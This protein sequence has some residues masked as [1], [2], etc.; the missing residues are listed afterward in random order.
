MGQQEVYE[1]LKKSKK[2]MSTKQIAEILCCNNRKV[3][4]LLLKMSKYDEVRFVYND[5]RNNNR[6]YDRLYYI[7]KK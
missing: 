4:T 6:Q 2:P 7:P 5:V 1:L 3:S